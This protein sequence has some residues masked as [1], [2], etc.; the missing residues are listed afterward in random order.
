MARNQ[1][2]DVYEVVKDGEWRTLS[3]IVFKMTSI[4]P[5]QSVGARLRDLRKPFYGCTVSKRKLDPNRMRGAWEYR[6]TGG[7][8]HGIDCLLG[9]DRADSSAGIGTCY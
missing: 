1:L 3:E 7:R 2:R 8:K 6:V 4:A 5:T 9:R